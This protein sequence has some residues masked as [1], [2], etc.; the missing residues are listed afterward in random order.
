M[1]VT[2]DGTEAV[3]DPVALDPEPG[4]G[5]GIPLPAEV[6]GNRAMWKHSVGHPPPNTSTT[7]PSIIGVAS[8]G[9]K[10]LVCNR[11]C[12][13]NCIESQGGLGWKRP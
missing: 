12:P 1:E 11:V 5:G 2:G 10:E 3:T 9:K 13:Y 7:K 4:Q 6:E 8:S